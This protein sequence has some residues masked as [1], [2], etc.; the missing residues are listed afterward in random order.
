MRKYLFNVEK[1]KYVK[2]DKPKVE[3]IL[4]EIVKQ[5]PEVKSLELTRTKLN[6]VTV[7][8]YPFNPGHLMI[9]PLRHIVSPAQLNED[10]ALDQH[11][12]LQRS[13]G[14]L[15]EEF[16]PHGYNIGYN[17]GEDSGASI[18]HIHMHIVPRYRNE[19]GFIDVLAGDRISIVDPNEVL[20]RL[21]KK[22]RES[23]SY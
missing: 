2:G 20:A 3:C 11:R 9:F 5:N 14:I 21:E 18:E 13:M 7:N 12:L 8:L 23:R 17:V 16:T 22:F 1:F 15:E 19:V 4:C 10:E 6:A